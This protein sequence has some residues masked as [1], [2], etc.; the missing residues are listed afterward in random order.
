M[1]MNHTNATMSL[2]SDEIEKVNMNNI[3]N[4]MQK[5]IDIIQQCVCEIARDRVL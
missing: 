1:R 5:C 4:I 3:N 2:T